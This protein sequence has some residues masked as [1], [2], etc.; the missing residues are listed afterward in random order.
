VLEDQLV[1]FLGAYLA[2]ESKPVNMVTQAG[3]R[4]ER[5]DI[6][7]DVTDD[8]DAKSSLAGAAQ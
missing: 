2:G 4:E 6:P 1:W 5:P 3:L 8:D 7:W